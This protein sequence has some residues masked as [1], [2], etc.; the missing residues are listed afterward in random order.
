MTSRSQLSL[1]LRPP[2]DSQFITIMV[3]SVVGS[4]LKWG[5]YIM[6]HQQD[7]TLRV[8]RH[9]KWTSTAK[10]LVSCSALIWSWCW[11]AVDEL[12]NLCKLCVIS[13]QTLFNHCA[14]FVQNVCLHRHTQTKTLPFE[15]LELLSLLKKLV[16]CTSITKSVSVQ[17]Y[18]KP[19]V[20]T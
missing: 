10:V 17:L 7:E 4:I 19:Q 1:F 16:Y 18:T 20:Y 6:R 13:M 9:P 5:R 15:L 14:N 8:S 12:Q 3:M 2:F 11:Q